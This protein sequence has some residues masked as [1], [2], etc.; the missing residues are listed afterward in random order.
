VNGRSRCSVCSALL[1][2]FTTNHQWMQP[3]PHLLF[4][5]GDM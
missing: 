2:F 1:L 5:Q 4:P 3:P